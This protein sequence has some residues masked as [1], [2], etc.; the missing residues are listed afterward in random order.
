M[1]EADS[2]NDQPATDPMTPSDS[3]MPAVTSDAAD[4]MDGDG[5]Q[6]VD[7]PGAMS[8]DALLQNQSIPSKPL[9][10][11]G[12]GIEAGVIHY[13]TAEISPEASNLVAFPSEK[14]AAVVQLQQLEKENAE[15]RDRLR[16]AELDL[17]QHQIEWQ[18][19][20]ARPV[21]TETVQGEPLVS[22]AS[23]V[24]EPAASFELS[25]D[26]LTQIRQELERTQ[27]TAQRQQ[28]LVETLTE[29]LESSQERIA[30]LERDCALTQQRYNEQVQQVLQVESTCRDLRLRLHRQQQ[31]TL[32]F[33]AAL[34][35]C[36]EMPTA[37]TSQ[38]LPEIALED[39]SSNLQA[40]S[41]LLKPKTQPVKPWSSPAEITQAG[42]N[43]SAEVPHP[44]FKLLNH[45]ESESANA[46]SQQGE[47]ALMS[48][49]KPLSD[50]ENSA[51]MI[52]SPIDPSA[53]LDSD[54]PQFVTQLMQLM[55]P[56][57]A[58]PLSYANNEPL[59]AAVSQAGNVFHLNAEPVKADAPLSAEESSQASISFDHSVDEL[60]T[61][62]ALT[63]SNAHV[64]ID[65]TPSDTDAI[66]PLAA[67]T[68]PDAAATDPLWHDL[69]ALIDPPVSDPSAIVDGSE[70]SAAVSLEGPLAQARVMGDRGGIPPIFASSHLTLTDLV[71]SKTPTAQTTPSL[72]DWT[73][74]DRLNRSS[75]SSRKSS[76]ER[77]TAETP[78]AAA[79]NPSKLLALSAAERHTTVTQ[80]VNVS[81]QPKLASAPFSTTMPSPI[82]YPL[83]SSKKLTSLAAVDLPTFPKR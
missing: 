50:G 11:F 72:S 70:T 34:E 62:P 69:A 49:F 77:A 22:S 39:D 19:E 45:G 52:A 37:Y 51:H 65:V 21:Q 17:V 26:R 14:S 43:D 9:E 60:I 20:S 56:D 64:A 32:Q 2:P 29:Q 44:F 10:A 35:K 24:A 55:F 48:A 31:Q 79:Q 73:W 75:K 27:Q 81:S 30:Q 47:D 8:V 38:A 71:S 68:P 57:A 23:V 54:D 28:I 12:E 67:S 5:W 66:A 33:K 15:L 4:V 76:V 61:L 25:H 59:E 16:Q 42:I 46:D 82:V 36:L 13:S 40:L 74:R 1:S 3:A 83:R 58:E 53:L 6:T 80:T 78:E 18:M 41:A 7:F 63:G